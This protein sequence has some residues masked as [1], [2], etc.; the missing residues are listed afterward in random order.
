MRVRSS[1]PSVLNLTAM[2]TGGLREA[3]MA[4][5]GGM[6]ISQSYSSPGSSDRS[7]TYSLERSRT[8]AITMKSGRTGHWTK[9]HQSLAKFSEP[10]ASDRTPFLADFATATPEL[11]FR[12]THRGRSERASG[13]ICTPAVPRDFRGTD[14]GRRSCKILILLDFWWTHKG[15]NLG[16]LPCEGNALPLSY[17][18]GISAHDRRPV[19]QHPIRANHA[20]RARDLRSAGPRCQAHWCQAVASNRGHARVRSA[21]AGGRGK[22]GIAAP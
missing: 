1:E 22:R 12:Y 20:V 13:D 7:I 16:P 2:V 17:A 6:P 9:M 4:K 18:S 14:R 5:P 11:S 21:A 19:N 10:E 15:S 3:E 8:Q